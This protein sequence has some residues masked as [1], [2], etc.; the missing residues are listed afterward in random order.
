M[1]GR[2]CFVIARGLADDKGMCTV[3]RMID[4]RAGGG[5]GGARWRRD[6]KK[7]VDGKCCLGIV[8]ALTRRPTTLICTFH[9]QHE[10]SFHFDMES[11]T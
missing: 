11:R 6:A 3:S 5:Y 10:R 8:V 7:K 4:V 9:D 2:D 1:C